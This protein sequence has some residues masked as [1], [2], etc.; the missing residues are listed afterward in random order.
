M[1]KAS[2]SCCFALHGLGRERNFKSKETNIACIL[3]LTYIYIVRY[4]QVSEA[5][6][7]L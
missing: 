1:E 2:I 7:K 5:V 4:E 3:F 6:L